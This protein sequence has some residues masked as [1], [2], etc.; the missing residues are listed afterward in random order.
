MI[1]RYLTH[2]GEKTIDSS[3]LT[4][5]KAIKLKCLDCS[6]GSKAE[7]RL[8]TV[9]DCPLY[10]F[11]IKT[12]KILTDEK[13]ASLSANMHRVRKNRCKKITIPD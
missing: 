5:A 7:V 6:G 8:C 13:K 2:S 1:V 10:Q 11:R 12:H 3:K 4:R 9:T